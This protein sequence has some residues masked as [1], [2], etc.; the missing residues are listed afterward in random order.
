MSIGGMTGQLRRTEPGWYGPLQ[1][2]THMF[3]FS[4]NQLGS[5]LSSSS[6]VVG[7]FSSKSQFGYSL[8]HTR[9]KRHV[10]FIGLLVTNGGMTRLWAVDPCPVSVSR[11]ALGRASSS[12][13]AGGLGQ[14]DVV[15]GAGVG[16]RSVVPGS[17]GDG[18]VASLSVVGLRR[19]QIS[20]ITRAKDRNRGQGPLPAHN[21]LI[22]P[23]LIFLISVCSKT[24]SAL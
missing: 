18:H 3:S 19:T 14:V 13:G 16:Q 12:F 24:R 11:S 6:H 8:L 5:L 1:G 21:F 22:K 20:H 17:R 10:G 4:L 23:A 2:E 9:Y 7:A 15:A